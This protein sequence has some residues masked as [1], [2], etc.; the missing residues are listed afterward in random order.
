MKRKII[1]KLRKNQKL[2]I[3]TSISLIAIAALT[4]AGIV[5]Y[6]KIEHDR[7]VQLLIKKQEL[8]IKCQNEYNSALE[9]ADK[10]DTGSNYSY[11]AVNWANLGENYNNSRLK[12]ER[13]EN[14]KKT[15]DSCLADVDK[16]K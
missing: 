15:Y 9:V 10:I 13:R 5:I 6:Q 11:G 16:I 14:A 12:I 3:I 2:I 4:T 8:R 1:D 7:Q